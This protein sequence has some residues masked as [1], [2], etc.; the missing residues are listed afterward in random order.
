MTSLCEPLREKVRGKFP[1]TYEEAVAVAKR[2]KKKMNL[3]HNPEGSLT[4]HE[5][6]P[7][8]YPEEPRRPAPGPAP[9][10]VAPEGE[11]AQQDVL[12]RITH[13]LENL[14]VNLVGGRPQQQNQE[15][16][17]PRPPQR[18]FLCHNC[19][20]AGHGMYYC[21]HPRQYQGN[22]YPRQARQQITPP[23]RP[24]MGFQNQAQP[25]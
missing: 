23:R 5:G 2:K 11:T 4:D 1:T 18:E 8:L 25:P 17:G 22:G 21:P 15:R 12:E 7:Q 24:P 16:R 6:C 20:E 3:H 10:G 13:Q 14:S 9:H 19:G